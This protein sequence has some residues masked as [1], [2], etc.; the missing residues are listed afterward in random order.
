MSGKISRTGAIVT[1]TISAIGCG[2]LLTPSAFGV[3]GYGYALASLA[4]VALLTFYT[5]Y[6]IAY[7]ATCLDCN[8]NVSYASIGNKIS[9]VLRVIIDV[10]LIGSNF[11]TTLFIARTFA[12]TAS[13]LFSEYITF[14]AEETLR[15]ISGGV[16]MFICILFFSMESLSSLS[17]ISNIGISSVVYYCALVIYY[18]FSFG[19]KFS[20]LRIYDNQNIPSGFMKFIFALHCQFAF[21][22][23]F[24]EMKNNSMKEVSLTIAAACSLLFSIYAVVGFFGYKAVGPSI[25]GKNF[26]NI[27]NDPSQPL[28]QAIKTQSFDKYL[29]LPKI[30]QACFLLVFFGACVFVTHPLIGSIQS[31][32]SS[33]RRIIKRYA[34]S[35]FIAGA[36]FLLILPKELD[37]KNIMVDLLAALFTMPLSFVFPSIFVINVSSKTSFLSIAGYLAILFGV[38]L[39]G[40]QIYKLLPIGK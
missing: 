26:L 15:K 7:S 33:P 35:P 40:Y 5:L 10:T 11:I 19:E 3:M 32:L 28:T 30:L 13:K 21:P 25:I 18:A 14:L 1:T 36:Y 39:S 20:E 23:I 27:V 24:S 22:S 8:K 17:F 2:I 31:Y 37:K 16:L 9:P 4:L 34:I 6:G 29:L 38:L 12:E